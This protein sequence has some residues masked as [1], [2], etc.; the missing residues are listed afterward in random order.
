MS[1]IPWPPGTQPSAPTHSES[2]VG[3]RECTNVLAKGEEK[4]KLFQRARIRAPYLHIRACTFKL[5]ASIERIQF[6]DT[7]SC[8]QQITGTPKQIFPTSKYRIRGKTDRR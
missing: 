6:W 3:P 1:F 2:S 4:T 8:G 7:R 5:K